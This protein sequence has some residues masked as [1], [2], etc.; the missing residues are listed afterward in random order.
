L[1]PLNVESVAW[2]AE[3]KNVLSLGFGLLS[4]WAYASYAKNGRRSHYFLCSLLL[5]LGLMAKPMLVSWPLLFVLLDHWP[6]QRTTWSRRWTPL[7]AARAPVCPK[8]S[9]TRL[10]LEKL[11]LLALGVASSVLTLLAQTRAMES[12]A[13]IVLP[14]RIANAVVASVRYLGKTLWP[15]DLSLIYPH[16]YLPG[17]T[18]WNAAQIAG[19]ALLLISI[20]ALALRMRRRPYLVIGWLWYAVSLIP[21]LGL[22]QVGFV[23]MADRYAYVP[24][25]GIFVMFAWAAADTV[26]ALAR[27][28]RRAPQLAAA[29]ATLVLAAGALRSA[30]QAAAWKNSESLYRRSLAATPGSVR[31]QQKLGT[32]LLHRGA[33]REARDHLREAVRL[34][35]GWYPAAQNL[36][37]L[38]ATHPDPEI[39]DPASA[40]ELARIASAA[41]GQRDANILDTLAA[42]HAAAGEFGQATEVANR[43]L[44]LA[45]EQ[46]DPVLAAA[47]ESHLRLYEAGQAYFEEKPE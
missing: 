10:L 18:P 20:S 21:V 41:R 26:D 34:W 15:C 28:Q 27:R 46:R 14:L 31:L 42:A 35:P 3:R 2:I 23:G 13:G 39:R 25:I 8:A 1:H 19:S 12:A 22:V 43:A 24:L 32:L 38:Q 11:P 44:A 6:L 40:L 16:P 17:G 37:W 45:Q 47:I 4:L 29:L 33:S 5:A 36:A 7:G 9:W 30:D